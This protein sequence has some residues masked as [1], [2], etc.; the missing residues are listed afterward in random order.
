MS[1]YI[2]RYR[3]IEKRE[4]NIEVVTPMFLGGSNKKEVELRTAS[5]KGLLRYWWRA[6]NPHLVVNND[7]SKLFKEES[8]IFGDAGDTGKSKI[9]IMIESK[10]F[11]PKSYNPLP[12]KTNNRFKFSGI[13][14][15]YKFKI[16]LIAPEKIHNLF[17][18]VS[19]VG[20]VGKR[21]R[22]GFGSFRIINDKNN[23]KNDDVLLHLFNLLEN[24][25]DNYIK[26]EKKI[27]LKNEL[28]PTYPFLKEI[29]LGIKSN[30][31]N[32]LLSKIGEASHKYNSD[33]TGYAK[34]INNSSY[35][36]SSPIYVSLIK[37]RQY[38]II[39]SKL[40][41]YSNLNIKGFGLQKKFIDHLLRN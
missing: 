28:N 41:F 14:E 20:A 26:E 38:Q 36:L 35:R 34:K 39:I 33:S 40:N 30:N 4:Y 25:N 15:G 11:Q 7:F 2:G 32:E 31:F 27:K 8:L 5:F 13:P 3:D 9:K 19:Y 16:Y 18:F 21:S 6:I 24:L 10:S 29:F 17:K 22:R 37:E 1:F 12:H 23:Q